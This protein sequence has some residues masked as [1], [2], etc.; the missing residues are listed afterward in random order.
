MS[1][2]PGLPANYDIAI[3]VPRSG[4]TPPGRTGGGRWK[5]QAFEW[6]TRLFALLVFSIL[7]AILVSLVA[8]SMVS[9]ERYGVAFLWSDEWDPVKEQF[10]AL[11]PDRKSTRLN[12]S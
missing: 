5:D 12:S 2:V 9:L 11:V 7:G 10:G 3:S 4:V 6:L 1:A 8:G